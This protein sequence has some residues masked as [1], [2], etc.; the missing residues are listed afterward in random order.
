M[1]TDLNRIDEFY[2]G[3]GWYSDGATKQIDYYIGFAMHFTDWFT[4]RQW[5]RKIRYEQ[6]VSKKEQKNL[7]KITY[8]GL[9]RAEKRC[10]TDVH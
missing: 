8:T 2:L 6:S 3:D 1:E 9:E 7:P 4:P 10:L 5:V